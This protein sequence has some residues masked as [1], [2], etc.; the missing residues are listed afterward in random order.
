M[1]VKTSRKFPGNTIRCAVS[2]A[3]AGA[4]NGLF[5]AGGGM[6]VVPLFSRWAKIEDRHTYAS[7]VAVILPLSVVSA[8][9]YALRGAVDLKAAAP[10]L[11]G[12]AAGG[13]LGGRMFKKV[14][15]KILKRAFALLLIIAG[16][17]ALFS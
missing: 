10:Y 1:E 11:F 14:P 16:L 3:F 17:R 5:G 12:G 2:G 15:P 13:F 9:I 8:V 4:A 7:S 6:F